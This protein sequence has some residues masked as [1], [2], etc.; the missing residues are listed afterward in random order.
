MT[1]FALQAPFQPE[2][3]HAEVGILIGQFEIARVV[4]GFGNA[5]RQPELRAVLDLT[6]HH[7]PIGLIEQTSGRRAHDERRHQIFE[8]RA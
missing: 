4:R 1:R 2:A 5:P 7:E 6:T 8:H 3:G